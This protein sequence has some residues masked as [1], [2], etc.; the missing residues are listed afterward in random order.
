MLV[1]RC[2]ISLLRYKSRLYCFIG[3][4]VDD[5]EGDVVPF[6]FMGVLHPEPAGVPFCSD[7]GSSSSCGCCAQSP[8][9]LRFPLLMLPLLLLWLMLLFVSDILIFAFLPGLPS[10]FSLLLLL[11]IVEVVAFTIVNRKIRMSGL[12]KSFN[13]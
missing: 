7:P 11:F 4:D 5:D 13:E 2:A 1:L 8:F 3:V 9:D 12:R 6:I 10:V